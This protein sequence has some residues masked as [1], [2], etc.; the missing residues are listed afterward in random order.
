M[1]PRIVY[2]RDGAYHEHHLQHFSPTSESASISLC[3]KSICLQ[4]LV[5]IVFLPT[6]SKMTDLF[7]TCSVVAVPTAMN[8]GEVCDSIDSIRLVK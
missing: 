4:I 5:D 8:S 3:H 1:T 7:A 2:I 6:F